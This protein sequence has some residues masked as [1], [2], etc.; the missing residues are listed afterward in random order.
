MFG[1]VEIYL[2]V[3]IGECKCEG[4]EEKFV[5][6]LQTQFAY[7]TETPNAKKLVFGSQAFIDRDIPSLEY[8]RIVKDVLVRTQ[9]GGEGT[10][11]GGGETQDG[12]GETGNVPK[13]FG[14]WARARRWE[15]IHGVGQSLFLV[16]G[17]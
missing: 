9:D 16:D 11:D 1:L 5:L 2:G 10:Q 12:G 14:H 13:C 3:I 4:E 6:P 7:Y 8:R 17:C 15:A